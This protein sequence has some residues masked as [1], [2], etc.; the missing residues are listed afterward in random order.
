MTAGLRRTAVALSLSRFSVGRQLF[1]PLT[2]LSGVLPAGLQELDVH[3]LQSC[4]I[5]HLCSVSECCRICAA[6]TYDECDLAL[7]AAA[8]FPASLRELRFASFI[9]EGNE[10]EQGALTQCHKAAHGGVR[11]AIRSL[12]EERTD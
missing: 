4:R 7:I 2:A 6:S 8:L 3:A 10:I 5:A 9:P 12:M 11:T 1:I